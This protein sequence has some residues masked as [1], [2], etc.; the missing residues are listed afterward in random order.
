MTVRRFLNGIAA[1]KPPDTGEIVRPFYC[2][3]EFG[4]TSQDSL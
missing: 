4:G 2:K 1:A 3:D